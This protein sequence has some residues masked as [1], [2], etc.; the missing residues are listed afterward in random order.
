MIFKVLSNFLLFCFLYFY[1]SICICLWCI[2]GLPSIHY[3]YTF[4]CPFSFLIF[5]NTCPYCSNLDMESKAFLLLS[6][7]PL[8]TFRHLSI[9][10]LFVSR[11]IDSIIKFY[12][13]L[14]RIYTWFRSSAFALFLFLFCCSC[15]LHFY[16]FEIFQNLNT[17]KLES[18]ESD[19]VFD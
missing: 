3:M 5:C 15:L 6:S 9:H 18:L 16:I 14:H 2:W 1:F 11:F 13:H 19:F 12:F 8:H 17:S 7:L 10:H 4:Q